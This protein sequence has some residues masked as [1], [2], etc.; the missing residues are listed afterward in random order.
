MRKVLEQAGITEIDY[1]A[2][3]NPDTLES[4]SEITGPALAVLAVRVGTTRLIDNELLAAARS[5]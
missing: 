2:L 5:P 3:V 4:L 1:V